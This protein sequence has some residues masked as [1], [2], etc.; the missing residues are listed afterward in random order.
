MH[1]LSSDIKISNDVKF[2]IILD[3]GTNESENHKEYSDKKVDILII[4]HHE[5]SEQM[6][7]SPHVCIINNKD[8]LYPN[9]DLS[10]AGV[11][12]KFCSY[13]DSILFEDNRNIESLADLCAGAMVADMVSLKDY[14]TKFL[15]DKGLQNINNPFLKAII[16]KN[17][18][19]LKNEDIYPSDIS[20]SIAPFINAICRSGTQEEKEIVFNSL[21]EFRYDIEVPSTKKGSFI[22]ETETILSQALRICTNVKSRQ[23]RTKDKILSFLRQ[24]IAD[25]HI[26]VMDN[27]L[28]ITLDE[29]E[30]NRNLNGLV[31]NELVSEFNKPTMILVK[32]NNSY[33]GSIR[34]V[35]NSGLEDFR[36]ACEDT[37]YAEFAQ[38][39]ANSAGLSVASENLENFRDSLNQILAPYNFDK[40]Y[41]V[42]FIFPYKNLS[43]IKNIILEIADMKSIWGQG[44]YES[45]I[46][47]EGV[48]VSASNFKLMSPDKK[49]TIKIASN[50]VDF[51]KFK[52]HY[53]E[54]NKLLDLIGEGYITLNI[55][56][57][58]N[59][60]EWDNNIY[61]QI[62]IKDYEVI[63]VVSYDF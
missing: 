28:L 18:F 33:I 23:N 37:G 36:Q 16:S 39:H 62:I 34:G 57:S 59:K 63:E 1:G 51:I 21:L 53:E 49:P 2:I 13:L 6:F 14:E 35:N 44:V 3:A 26:G 45:L 10:G 52:S 38:G 48:K 17:S 60:N 54:Y 19:M 22:G 29:Q 9:P 31:A 58:C 55:V 47:I 11:V 7:D 4:D 24:K 32:D 15:L 46:A 40:V 25:E 43:N 50:G 56:G 61:P 42:D 27:F 30:G 20:F 12:Y 41:K 5:I 8:G